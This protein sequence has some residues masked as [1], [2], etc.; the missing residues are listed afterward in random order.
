V[1]QNAT[2]GRVG[3]QTAKLNEA[4]S[5]KVRKGEQAKSPQDVFQ[6]EKE[7]RQPAEYQGVEQPTGS[8]VAAPE[9]P[10][11]VGMAREPQTGARGGQAGSP[12]ATSETAHIENA[13]VGATSVRAGNSGR[14]SPLAT[15][16]VGVAARYREEQQPG[17][18]EPG[19]I[20]TPNTACPLFPNALTRARGN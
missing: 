14:T 12:A 16:D 7:Q 9:Q 20:Q 10:A 17:S 15:N 19:S 2:T 11:G 8:P 1:Q 5:N 3:A 18:V 6:P 13:P 4:Q